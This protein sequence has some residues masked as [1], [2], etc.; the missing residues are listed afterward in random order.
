MV[1][2]DGIAGVFSRDRTLE[3]RLA[4]EA[5]LARALATAGVTTTAVADVIA[6]NC[7]AA[8]I[9]VDRLERDSIVAGNEAIPLVEQLRARV[10][11]TD[12]VA[13]SF[14]HYGATSQDVID[15]AL[16]LQ[17]RAAIVAFDG[18]LRRLI[19]TLAEHA[20]AES[21]TPMVA[22]TW[23]QH[24]LPTTFGFKVAGWLDDV[25]HA[26]ARI[27]A[28]EDHAIALQFGGAVGTLAALGSHADSVAKAL[29]A[30]L[31]LPLPPIAWHSTRDRIGEVATAMGLLSATFGKIARD[32]SLMMQSEVDEVREPSQAGR[33]RS[34]TM[35]HKRNPVGC[36]SILAAAI[37][38]PG[39]VATILHGMVQEH[40]RALGGWQAEWE[41]LPQL[42][43]LTFDAL[44]QTT[45]VVSG[46]EINRDRM[47]AN[48]EITKGLV[49]AEA[50]TFALGRC[51]GRQAAED[52]TRR[53]IRRA[54][55]EQRHLRDVLLDDRD[56]RAQLS[57]P[58]VEALFDAR[59]YLGVA[60]E[61]AKRVAERARRDIAADRQ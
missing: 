45:I 54:T 7:T 33:G 20:A 37:R 26:H 51:V 44:A 34:S 13:A 50:V 4:F 19:A 55:D 28:L 29:S 38:A 31:S 39:L 35:P 27:W 40:E 32:L 12:P 48:L 36:A 9:D 22:R 11:E 46:L 23:M 42:C 6:A 18:E 47:M 5:S 14:V 17:L 10:A 56:V 49:F 60:S 58:D 2:S 25:Q 1:S 3:C 16:M 21:E 52:L 8:A 24:A 53:A 41:T 57:T 59:R 43:E 30:E 15:T 61:T